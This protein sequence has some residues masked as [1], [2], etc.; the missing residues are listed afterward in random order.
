MSVGVVFFRTITLP[1]AVSSLNHLV[2]K[3]W[4]DNGD[5]FLAILYECQRTSEVRRASGIF[6]LVARCL[7]SSLCRILL[8]K[9]D[10]NLV[11]I[12]ELL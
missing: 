3:T 6:S 10:C 1:M 2:M 11:V 12:M 4:I 5:S 8:Y 7:H 9:E